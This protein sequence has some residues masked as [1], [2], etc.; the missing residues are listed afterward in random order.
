MGVKEVADGYPVSALS[1]DTD[2]KRI[3]HSVGQRDRDEEHPRYIY[4]WAT[5]RWIR[6][7]AVGFVTHIPQQVLFS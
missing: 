2:S 3:V 5:Q 1:R 4:V 6:T 7:R